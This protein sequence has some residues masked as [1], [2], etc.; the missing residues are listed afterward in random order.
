MDPSL[1][2]PALFAET[3]PAAY[4]LNGLLALGSLVCFIIVLIEMFGRGHLF[5]GIATILLSLCCGLG[6]IVAFIVG[7]MN[8]DRWNMRTV[9]LFWTAIV[10]VHVILYL[11]MPIP[12]PRETF[13]SVL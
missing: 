9:M 4:G 1:A 11:F 5:L 3:S 10:I 7:W 2:Q 6:T 12:I 8:A 13:N